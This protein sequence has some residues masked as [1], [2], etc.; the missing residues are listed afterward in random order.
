M[1]YQ[2]INAIPVKGQQVALY[3]RVISAQAAI[4]LMRLHR[5]FF[6]DEAKVKPEPVVMQAILDDLCGFIAT[7]LD[8]VRELA[9]PNPPVEFELEDLTAKTWRDCSPDERKAL[10]GD[11][12]S[13]LL[14]PSLSALLRGATPKTLGESPAG[15]AS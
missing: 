4:E 2:R 1:R 8:D 5:E 12:S 15:P 6:G 7:Y 3:L 14:W 9:E 11:F 13:V 10:V